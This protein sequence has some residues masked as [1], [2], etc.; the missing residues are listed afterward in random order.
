[1]SKLEYIPSEKEQ[2]M[3]IIDNFAFLKVKTNANGS[4]FWRRQEYLT[5]I[6]CKFEK[7]KEKEILFT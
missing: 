7:L 5:A 4:I 1:M 6:A 3:L 2:H